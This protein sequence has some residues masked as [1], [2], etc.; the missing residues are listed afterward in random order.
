M[1]FPKGGSNDDENE[2]NEMKACRELAKNIVPAMRA[3]RQDKFASAR[4]AKR[5]DM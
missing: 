2:G 4:H 1:S 3:A 5:K